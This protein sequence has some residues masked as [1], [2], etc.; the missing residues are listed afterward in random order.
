M[1]KWSNKLLSILLWTW[2]GTT[3]FFM[4]VIWKSINGRP[5]QISWTMLAL[6][7]ILCIPLERCG[8]ELPWNC[9]LIIQAFICST[10]IT[11]VELISGVII[12]IWL[13]M[14]VWDYSNLP[15]NV[16][17]QICPQFSLI[18]FALCF[19]FIPIFDMIRYVIQGGEKPYYHLFPKNNE[20]SDI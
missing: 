18:W 20:G 1:K 17:G 6:A 2:G 15:G 10:A 13:S 7:I 19:I 11:L 5:E 16:L 4:E 9:P 14:N 3:Y 8:A 12:N